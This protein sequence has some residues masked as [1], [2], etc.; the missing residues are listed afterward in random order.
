M[1]LVMMLALTFTT[2]IVDAIGYLGLDK[3]FT[4]N[5]TGNVVILGMALAGAPGLPIVGP[6][7]ALF[8]F[9]LGA[10]L[11]GRL[12]KGS[13]P[14]WSGHSTTAFT[15]AGGL[16][17]VLGIGCLFVVPAQN[18]PWAYSITGILGAAMG[19]QAGAARKLAVADVT[20]VVVTSTIVGLAFESKLAGGHG[21]NFPRRVLAVVLIL[22]GAGVG[23]L[24][25]RVH[26]GVGMSVAGT[27][28]LTVAF[29]GH[30]VR[31]RRPV[32]A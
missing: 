21:K 22:A 16:V 7:I 2:G 9:L 26:I 13:R 27:L 29:L 24:L 1:H 8:A 28:M 12:M 19:L 30:L 32:E 17:L 6:V 31:E 25:L 5:M 18:S 3:V 20:T 11:G 15:I 10:A 14:G 23:A 4:A